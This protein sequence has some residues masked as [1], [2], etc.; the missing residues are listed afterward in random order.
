[1]PRAKTQEVLP[2]EAIADS[3]INMGEP[4]AQL[5]VVSQEYAVAKEVGSIMHRAMTNPKF[6]PKKMQAVMDMQLQWQRHQAEIAYNM[7][8]ADCQGE[9]PIIVPTKQHDYTKKFYADLEDID[10]IVRPLYRKHGFSISFT[11]KKL[12]NGELEVT[13]FVRHREGHKEPNS[14]TGPIDNVGMKGG[15]SKSPIEATCSTITRIQR[16]LLKMI[17]NVIVQGEDKERGKPEKAKDEFSEAV[18]SDAKA[19]KKPVQTKK[20]PEATAAYQDSPQLDKRAINM[21]EH[22]GKLPTKEARIKL[23]NANLTLINS[24]VAENMGDYVSQ[25]HRL[26]D[27]GAV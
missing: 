23:I 11:E 21:L 17:F 9:I 4:A 16:Y 5:P 3:K 12:D 14:F 10:L 25:M 18:Q 27:Q 20:G 22:L 15:Q 8:M 2:A 1:M 13:A 24:L 19:N 26:A 7:A 6:D